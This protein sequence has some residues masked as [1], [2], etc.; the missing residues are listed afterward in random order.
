MHI[1]TKRRNDNEN[2]LRKN[3]GNTDW[4]TLCCS[5]LELNTVPILGAQSIK[6]SYAV[7]PVFRFNVFTYSA[8]Y[9]T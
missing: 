1:R 5:Q 3:E 4:Y 2:S 9:D 6:K 7:T 8:E